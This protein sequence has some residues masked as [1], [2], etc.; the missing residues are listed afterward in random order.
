M[1]K[2]TA[3]NN[4]YNS[5]LGS[6]VLGKSCGFSIRFVFANLV[7]ETRNEI[8]HKHDGTHSPKANF[9]YCV[10]RTPALKVNVF[11]LRAKPN[12]LYLLTFNTIAFDG[13]RA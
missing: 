4:V 12:Y 3:G 1:N 13:H 5:L 9:N 8:I 2:I 11:H 10:L 6:F 7:A